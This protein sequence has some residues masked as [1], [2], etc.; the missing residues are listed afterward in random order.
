RASAW[1]TG[2][3]YANVVFHSSSSDC[4]LRKSATQSLISD[5]SCIL[6]FRSWISA[7]HRSISSWCCCSKSVTGWTLIVFIVYM[8]SVYN[9]LRSQVEILRKLLLCYQC[10]GL[11]TK[12]L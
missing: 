5:A 6:P 1:L 4:E 7:C 2:F 12:V 11:L 3:D 8:C 9:V 10:Q